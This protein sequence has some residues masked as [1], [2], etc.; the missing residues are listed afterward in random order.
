MHDTGSSQA[1]LQAQFRLFPGLWLASTFGVLLV[2]G[3]CCLFSARVPE[4]EARLSLSLL[5]AC[6]HSVWARGETPK[7]C[8]LALRF[9]PSLVSVIQEAQLFHGTARSHALPV[10]CP[11]STPRLGRSVCAEP[12]FKEVFAS[13]R[14]LPGSWLV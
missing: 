5:L 6:L 7:P 3:L 2:C 13:F 14:A 10:Q 9:S 12:L 11:T 1:K 4:E 8:A